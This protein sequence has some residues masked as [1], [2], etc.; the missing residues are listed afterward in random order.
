MKI[1]VLGGGCDDCDRFYENVLIALGELG[2]DAEV[3]RV[4]DLIEIVKLGVM[5]VPTLIIDG[6][7][8]LL[9]QHASAER[10]KELIKANE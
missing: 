3:E 6:K 8:V 2:A 4:E 10:I 9:G 1:K 7:I 5:S